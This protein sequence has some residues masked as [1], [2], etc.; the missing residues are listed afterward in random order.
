[1]TLLEAVMK[2]RARGDK[3][4]LLSYFQDE[5]R[6]VMVF[7]L[8]APLRLKIVV[9]YRP[10][11]GVEREAFVSVRGLSCVACLVKAFSEFFNVVSFGF[12]SE[13][14]WWTW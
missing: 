5:E 13:P 3:D 1:M 8:E 9:A 14:D 7:A 12:E 10:A 4:A 11:V 6:S 2:G